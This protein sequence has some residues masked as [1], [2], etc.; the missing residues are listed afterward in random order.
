MKTAS[1]SVRY[2]ALG[3]TV[4]LLMSLGAGAQS[5]RHDKDKSDDQPP[6]TILDSTDAQWGM[7]SV[8]DSVYQGYPMNAVYLERGRQRL[9][10]TF[11]KYTPRKL[12]NEIVVRSSQQAAPSTIRVN[13]VETPLEKAD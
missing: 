13:G 3:A 2:L 9:P 10:D 4:V 8:N 12:G 1:G 7:R 6:I 11:P 5:R